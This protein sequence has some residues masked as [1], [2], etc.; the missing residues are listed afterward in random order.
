[1]IAALIFVIV[2]LICFHEFYWKRRNLPPGPTPL[3][4]IGNVIQ[5]HKSPHPDFY[6]AWTKQYGDIYTIWMG[7]WPLVCVSDYAAVHEHFLRDGETFADRHIPLEM[8]EIMKNGLTGIIFTDGPL[9]REHRRFA[10]SVFRDFGVGKNVMEQKI[11]DEIGVMFQEIDN[12]ITSG[13]VH[14]VMA[15]HIDITVGSIINNLLMGH[16]YHGEG[17]REEFFKIKHMLADTFKQFTKP[18]MIM[19]Q[20]RTHMFKNWPYLGPLYKQITH[21]RDVLMQYFAD[22]VKRKR[23]SVNFNSDTPVED[24]VEAYLKKQKELIDS[25]E[26][27]TFD[28]EQLLGTMWD[29]WVAGQETTSNTTQWCLAFLLKH[30]EVQAKLQAE[31]SEFVS[32]DQIVTNDLRNR[33]PYANAI[34]AE[35]Q[36]VGNI[37]PTNVVHKT[38]KDTVIHG[39]KIPAGQPIVSHISAMLYDDRYFPEPHTFKPE[40][41]IDENGAFKPHPALLPFGIGKRACL[42]EALAKMELFL[43]ITNLFNRYK[44]TEDPEHPVSLKRILSGT[45][46]PQPYKCVV[47]KRV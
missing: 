10:L 27:H 17:R 2:I 16:K 18:G 15:D 26:L 45:I 13:V 38:T 8:V 3:P 35:T 30:P 19:F 14:P 11:L 9:W 44:F 46:L 43:I 47:E 25:G 23:E 12:D 37:V 21:S 39:Y 33:L 22:N 40:R 36:R 24:F 28:D 5:F 20:T 32:P 29:L 34:V 42:G 4:I 6:T 1:M 41:F 31:L 7:T